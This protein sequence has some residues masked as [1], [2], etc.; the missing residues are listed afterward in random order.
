MKKLIAIFCFLLFHN[1]ALAADSSDT[2]IY[3]TYAVKFEPVM[4]QGKL[5]SCGLRFTAITQ[6]SAY[7]DGAVY[8]VTGTILLSLNG[9]GKN[10]VAG[11]KVVNNKV[12]LMKPDAAP[13][14]KKPYFAYLATTKGINNADGLLESA[15]SDTAGGIF[16]VFRFDKNFTEIF[17]QIL[18]TGTISVAFN[19]KKGGMDIVV[20]LDFT[21]AA[22]N[23]KGKRTKSPVMMQEFSK[24]TS[25]LLN[26]V[27]KNLK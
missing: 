24:C 15:D 3:G 7:E 12:N 2:D 14:P 19:L 26:E 11:L 25:T 13:V 17:H 21:V 10:I 22:V 6:S 23:E 1:L 16:S 4:V 8:G 5:Q 27:S 9:G 18:N 20:P